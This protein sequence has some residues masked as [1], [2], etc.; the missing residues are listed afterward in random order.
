M[1]WLNDLE[2]AFEVW[3]VSAAVFW[4][5]P[6]FTFPELPG[7]NSLLR[8]F[9]RFTRI[10]LI[11]SVAVPALAS[12]HILNAATLAGFYVVLF[13]GFWVSR[14]GLSVAALQ[15]WFLTKV[16]QVENWYNRKAWKEPF[17]LRKELLISQRGAYMVPV[18]GTAAVVF[19]LIAEVR[20]WWPI[21]NLR[22]AYPDAYVH[23]LRIRELL[24]DTQPFTQPLVVP[25]I[26]ASVASLGA[27]DA[28][29]VT[30]FLP[31]LMDILL[32]GGVAMAAVFRSNWVGVF[33]A[34]VLGCYTERSIVSEGLIG[35]FFL[36][37]GIA[38]LA[39][40]YYHSH[41]V[42]LYD[43]L[44]AFT[45]LALSLPQAFPREIAL[46]LLL[47]CALG[48]LARSAHRWLPAYHLEALLPLLLMAG[49]F[50]GAPPAFPHPN[51]LEYETTAR[52]SLRIAATFPQQHWAVV[53]PAE[54]FSE[55]LGLGQYEDLYHFV[56]EYHDRVSD[57]AFH[58]PYETVFVFV[59]K[60]PFQYFAS[61]PTMVSFSILTDPT[62]RN[63]R[64]PAGRS[65]VELATMKLCEIY[66]DLHPSRV[67]FEDENLRIYEFSRNY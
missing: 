64:S 58:F 38:F 10:V 45:L 29:Q 20:L 12:L 35:T 2:I 23:L 40:Y 53:A 37:L 42:S 44:C 52:Q 18:L 54:Q 21:H 17:R 27:V 65:S 57:P 67:F 5:L 30:R 8:F 56:S 22:F 13:F 3:L 7:R 1:H 24:H 36:L 9:G 32:A 19:L 28:M 46:T 51:F 33:T 6:R 34:F 60:R 14:N 39:D 43:A 16:A 25:S 47:S 62:Y 50:I 59:E 31:P 66:A 63:Y 48:F 49:V 41:R 4:A 26:F 15:R 55:T 11:T 61:E